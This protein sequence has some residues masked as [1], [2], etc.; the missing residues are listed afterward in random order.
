MKLSPRK[1]KTLD[2]ESNANDAPLGDLLSRVQNSGEIL[3]G[4]NTRAIVFGF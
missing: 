3:D 2:H 4:K 1:N